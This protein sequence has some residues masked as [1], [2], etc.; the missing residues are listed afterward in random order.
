MLQ[1]GG[2][3]HTTWSRGSWNNNLQFVPPCCQPE[4][5]KGETDLCTLTETD[6]TNTED[7]VRALKPMKDATTLMSEE[8][9]MTVSL[10]A[11]LNAQLLQNMS[12]TNG[13]SHMI[14]EIKNAIRT[15]LLKRYNSE[16]Q[17]KIL[18]TASALDPRFKGMP[19]HT[20]EERS[21]N[22]GTPRRT[23]VDEA[24][25]GTGTLGRKTSMEDKPSAAPKRKASSLLVCLPGQSFT[26]TEGTV[27]P[28]TP[29]VIAKDP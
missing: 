26:D 21:E 6:V 14:H 18:H 12:D 27:E 7:A 2:T 16:S 11:P 29:Y 3:A 9:N 22:E 8:R 15:D 1:Q 5:I 25:E 19:F 28:K 17:K 24:P 10:I 23:K 13:D 4:V 20:E